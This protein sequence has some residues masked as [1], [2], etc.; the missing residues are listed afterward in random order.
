VEALCV[1]NIRTDLKEIHLGG[2]DWIYFGLYQ[3]WETSGLA[4]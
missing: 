2:V 3:E 4:Y 1:D